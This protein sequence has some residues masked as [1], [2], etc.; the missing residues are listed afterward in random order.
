M[1]SWPVVV[2]IPSKASIR[3]TATK[4]TSSRICDVASSE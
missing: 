3:L 2:I 1:T 4:V